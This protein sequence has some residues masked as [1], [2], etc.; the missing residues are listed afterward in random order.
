MTDSLRETDIVARYGGEEFAIV[1]PQTPLEGAA[2]NAERLRKLI[3]ERIKLTVSIGVAAAEDGENTQVLLGRADQA[4]Q[5]AKHAGRNLV[6]R[7]DGE[8]IAV[9]HGTPAEFAEAETVVV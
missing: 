6:Y 4:L 1:M 8:E 9:V 2:G 5:S 3:Q 7:H